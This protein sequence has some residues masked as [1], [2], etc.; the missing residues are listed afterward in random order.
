LLRLPMELHRDIIDYI[1]ALE[2]KVC[3]RLACRYFMS[4]IKHPAQ[5][6]FLIAETRA[7]AIENNLYTCK[8]CGNFRHLLKFADN[9]RKGKRARHGVDA[10]TRFCVNCGVAHHLYTPGTEVTILGQLYVVCRLCGT[11]TDQVGAKGAC[12]SC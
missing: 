12:S 6:D 11:F 3:L 8:Y 7:F 1:K 2:D 4:I 10:N 9:M 5:E